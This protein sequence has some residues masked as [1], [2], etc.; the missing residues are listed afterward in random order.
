MSVGPKGE[1]PLLP[2]DEGSTDS[3]ISAFFCCEHGLLQQIPINILA[4]INL[5]RLGKNY[6]DE[7]AAIEVYGGGIQNKPLTAERSPFLVVF[8]VEKTEKDTRRILE[9]C[10]HGAPVQRCC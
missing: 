7:E 1:W 4:E 3:M 6:A 2:K 5:S 10:P 9:L 8:D